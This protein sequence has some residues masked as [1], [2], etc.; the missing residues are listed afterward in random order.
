MTLTPGAKNISI[1]TATGRV[2]IPTGTLTPN[3]KCISIPTKTGTV[4]VSLATLAPGDKVIVVS[5]KTGRVLV[6]AGAAAAP[7]ILVMGGYDGTNFLNDI[8][9]SVD[10][11]ETWTRIKENAEWSARYGHACVVMSDGSLVLTGGFSAAGYM[12]DTWYSTDEG[13]TWTQKSATATWAGRYNHRMCRLSDDTLILTA[14]ARSG[15]EGSQDV[16][17]STNLGATWTQVVATAPWFRRNGHGCLAMADDSVIIWGGGYGTPFF[18][19]DTWRSTDQGANWTQIKADDNTPYV[20]RISFSSAR[21]GSDI[22]MLGGLAGAGMFLPYGG[23]N[24][25]WKSSNNGIDWTQLAVP[26]WSARLNHTSVESGGS[27]FVIGGLVYSSGPSLNDVWWSRDGGTTWLQRTAAPG[28]SA[29]YSHA[30][31]VLA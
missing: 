26:A 23:S 2:V 27:L 1:P 10:N 7:G 20:R 3:G 5:T 12:N 8:W 9:K 24:Q 16:Y 18:L 30:S 14:G 6:K 28:W 15:Y 31:V 21:S 13:I 17:K 4:G 25:V 11:G 22:Y 29:R 19:S